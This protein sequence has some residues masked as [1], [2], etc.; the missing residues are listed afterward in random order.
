MPAVLRFACTLTLLA[1]ATA[2]AAS[3][4]TDVFEARAYR[5]DRAGESQSALAPI[6]VTDWGFEEAIPYSAEQADLL[7]R[8][9]D[10]LAVWLPADAST[11]S[12]G[13]RTYFDRMPQVDL[14]NGT[15]TLD[16][17]HRL[18]SRLLLPV[19]AGPS[20]SSYWIGAL[21]EGDYEFVLN[22]WRLPG[23]ESDP[24][25]GLLAPPS[26]TTPWTLDLPDAS[27]AASM[28][29]R[30]SVIPEPSAAVLLFAGIA[31]FGRRRV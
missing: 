13:T 14:A 4:S 31:A 7:L 17:Y 30:F 23:I 22:D 9:G 19:L 18:E 1:A 16:R 12:G 26:L 28:S 20:E 5:V 29:W 25:A 11:S 24:L 2:Q 10:P 6:G 15:V 27:L 3:T 21:P 8:S